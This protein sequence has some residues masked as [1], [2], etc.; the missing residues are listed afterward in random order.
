MNIEKLLPGVNKN[1]SLKNYTTFKVGGKAKYFFE[2]KTKKDLIN[3]IVVAR[4]LNIPF[5]L[6]A[7]GSNILFSD[8]GFSGLI[9]LIK[10][11]KYKISGTNI[12]AEA[13]VFFNVLVNESMKKGLKGLEWAA[14]LPGTVGGAVRG[15]AGAFGL[16]VKNNLY[17]VEFLDEKNKLRNFNNKQCKFKYRSSI[18]KEK[19][20]IIL[21][22][23]FL[24]KKGKPEEIKKIIEKNINYR[25]EKH[26]L[27]Y[28]SAGSVF[29]N[30]CLKKFSSKLK[31]ELKDVIKQDP[32]PVV[33]VAYL[34]SKT[35]LQ[36]LTI[37][38]AQVSKK[39]PNFIINFKKASA[40]DIKKLINL[41]KRKIKNKYNIKLEEEI[42][43]VN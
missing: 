36:G 35:K 18:F 8:K 21:S 34:I 41:I 16:E 14:G 40:Q 24:F 13:G 28:P 30:C 23:T 43:I 22:A 10:N 38:G 25:K 39:H 4:K 37:G 42:K 7:G 26:P 17:S 15:N 33:P 2:A 27:E 29:K 32:F 12:E 20:W 5:F 9:I 1:I 6:L 11:N 3:S 31:K 19:N